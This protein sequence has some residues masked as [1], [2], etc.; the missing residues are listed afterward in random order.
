M[1]QG[2][3]PNPNRQ[4]A[5]TS[6]ITGQASLVSVQQDR[7]RTKKGFLDL[8]IELRNYIYFMAL[9]PG[10]SSCDGVSMLGSTKI[11][12]LSRQIYAEARLYLQPYMPIYVLGIERRPLLRDPFANGKPFTYTS[13][14]PTSRCYTYQ[15][16]SEL[17]LI[18]ASKLKLIILQSVDSNNLIRDL[19]IMVVITEKSTYLKKLVLVVG[20]WQADKGGA[21]KELSDLLYRVVQLCKR[22]KIGIHLKYNKTI[23][24]DSLP[25]LEDDDSDDTDSNLIDKKEDIRKHLT[26]PILGYTYKLAKLWNIDLDFFTTTHFDSR[27]DEHGRFRDRRQTQRIVYAPEGDENGL[28]ELGLTTSNRDPMYDMPG[29][30][31]PDPEDIK[32]YVIVPEC[33]TCYKT[34]VTESGLRSHL[35]HKPGH[36]V[37]FRKKRWNPIS[38]IAG[39]SGGGKRVC[40]TCAQGFGIVKN[41][42]AHYEQFPHHKRNNIV[43]RCF[44][45]NERFHEYWAEHRKKYGWG[46]NES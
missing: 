1:A 20:R 34:F 29:F 16:C 40:V 30:D 33:R 27:I 9:K 19:K 22:K 18:R 5:M 12:S 46:V 10:K 13:W 45:D 17:E 38:P 39:I 25:F 15:R 3:S 14:M 24:S 36:A 2:P 8:P 21:K 11:L 41:P 31:H 43:P 42:D 28:T 44:E 6:T 23:V 7:V 32:P 26:R 4:I 35:Q 37:A